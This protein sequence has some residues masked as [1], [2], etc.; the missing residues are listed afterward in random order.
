MMWYVIMVV[1]CCFAIGD[2]IN[3]ANNRIDGGEI[4]KRNIFIFDGM[5]VEP[6]PVCGHLPKIC[7]TIYSCI[8]FCPKGHISVE[9]ACLVNRE[10][11][12]YCDWNA[13]VNK[14]RNEVI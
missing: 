1:I 10:H 12:C 13:T 3:R 6:C 2:M 7:R 9:S 5:K 4:M 8:V 14:Y 11:Q